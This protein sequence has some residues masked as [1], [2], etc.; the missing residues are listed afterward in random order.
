MNVKAGD[1]ELRE[2]IIELQLENSFLN[3]LSGLW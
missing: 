2:N 1:L 3:R